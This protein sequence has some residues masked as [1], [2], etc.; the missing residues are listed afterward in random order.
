MQA[1]S[2]KVALFKA[3]CT[4]L[5]TT[6]LWRRYKSSSVTI[7]MSHTMMA[8]SASLLFVHVDVPSCPAVLRNR[9]YRC[10]CRL[11]LSS[12]SI[13]E[14]LVNPAMSAVR[15][16]STLC[17]HNLHVNIWIWTVH[18]LWDEGTELPLFLS[19]SLYIYLSF[20]VTLFRHPSLLLPSLISQSAGATF[21]NR[22][23]TYHTHIT[24]GVLWPEYV[25]LT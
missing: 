17:R 25:N 8:S 21:T 10:M 18:G 22:K 3:F 19:I 20:S 14:V 13:I 12:N 16:T 15:F 24:C 11:T 23:P 5:Y 4:P 7:S 6:H 2:V 9:T 1:S